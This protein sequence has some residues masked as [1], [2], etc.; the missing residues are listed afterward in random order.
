MLYHKINQQEINFLYGSN[1]KI[2][3]FD[4]IYY[5]KN[6]VL[7]CPKCNN[8]LFYIENELVHKCPIEI[9]MLNV[10]IIKK[11]FYITKIQIII[12]VNV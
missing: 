5:D 11:I 2:K 8:L 4:Q 3:K 9:L 10:K 12:V 6:N 7:K 1:E